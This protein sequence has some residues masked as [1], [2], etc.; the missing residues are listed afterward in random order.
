MNRKLFLILL[1]ASMLL[2]SG[3]SSLVLR[4]NNIDSRQTIM[5]I[6]GEH[7]TKQSFMNTFS[8]NLQNEQYYAQ[9]M[10][11]FGASDGTVDRAEVLKSTTESLISGTVIAQKAEELGLDAFTD[12]ENADL[13][14]RAQEQYEQQLDV[15]KKDYL[16]GSDLSEEELESAAAAYMLSAGYT[17]ESIRNSLR[18]SDILARLR[19]HVTEAVQVGDGDLETALKE[20]IAADESRFSENANAF[21]TASSGN[22]TIYYTPDGYRLIRVYSISKNNGTEDSE[23][24]T[25]AESLLGLLNAGQEPEGNDYKEY[26]ITESSTLPNADTAAAAMSLAEIG[27]NTGIL[28]SDS[29]YVIAVYMEDIPQHTATLSE[30]YDDLYEQVLSAA[31]DKVYDSSV[32]EWIDRADIQ[33]FMDRLQ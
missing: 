29:T 11:Q 23:A 3:C 25:E 13:E 17:E 16:A 27:Q 7:I 26:R 4:D 31:Q 30:V 9:M 5:I 12:E 20:K 1:L 8:Y 14:R 33:A 18:S 15:V 2:L 28:E 32:Q 10:A 19:A 24:L 21:N 22:G 6:N